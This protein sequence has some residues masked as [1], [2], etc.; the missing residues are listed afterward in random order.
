M[1]MIYQIFLHLCLSDLVNKIVSSDNWT[2]AR[3][4][5]KIGK[6]IP[7]TNCGTSSLLHFIDNRLTDGG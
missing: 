4:S 2:I 5:K 1:S 7:V 6:A 3:D